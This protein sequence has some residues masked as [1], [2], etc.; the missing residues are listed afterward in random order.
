MAL[1]REYG[2]VSPSALNTSTSSAALA[3]PMN[4]LE[5]ET[6]DEY[7][8]RIRGVLNKKD[9]ALLEKEAHDIRFHKERLRGGVW[10]LLVFYDGVGAP[11]S[12]PASTEDYN[13]HLETLKTWVQQY[14]ES[15]IARIALAG[16]YQ[17]FAWFGR[18]GGYADSVSKSNWKLFGQRIE[19]AKS[20]LV[21]AAQL[22][23]KCPV[24]FEL[25][26]TIALDEGWHKS[27]AR[28]VLEAG[29]AFEP[30][31]YH[32][33]REYANYRLPKWSGEPGETQ[34]FADELSRRLPEPQGKIIYFEIATL[35]ACQCDPNTN[36][37]DGL[38]WPKIKE[39]YASLQQLY[40]IS[41]LKANRFAFMAYMVKDRPAARDAF[42]LIGDD[43]KN[44]IWQTP[45]FFASTKAWANSPGGPLSPMASVP[46]NN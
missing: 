38:A 20:A 35:N 39:G 36:N 15:A 34:A 32:Y 42:L 22:K 40:G 16:F 23:E 12:H 18:G 6:E 45:Q 25:V 29:V 24:W 7:S 21:E 41:T 28:E 5:L 14:P 37:L 8:F 11:E 27:L 2:K 10:K 17:G 31:Y 44:E 26:Q 33:Y 9:F 30:D 19:L 13:H 4:P 3:K 43:W 1:V 46:D